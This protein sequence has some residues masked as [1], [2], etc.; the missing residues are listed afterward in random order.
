MKNRDY[1]KLQFRDHS[2]KRLFCGEAERDDRVSLD[3][4]LSLD[5]FDQREL[6]II[7]IRNHLAG[8]DLIVRSTL[9]TQFASP[10]AIFRTQ[11]RSEDATRHRPG[12]VQ[13]TSSCR[14][15]ENG[16]RLIIG[17]G[18]K[19]GRT[20]VTL[21]ENASRRIAREI[22]LKPCDRVAGAPPDA[23]RS[24]RVRDLQFVQA[25]PQPQYV[26]LVNG[27]WANA[28]LRA[29]QTAGKPM[30][31]PLPSICQGC[32]HDLDQLPIAGCKRH[33]MASH[34]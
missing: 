11:R 18:G 28:A 7:G 1:K 10:Q 33:R 3:S 2:L 4:R 29:P 12:F 14:R 23:I 32:I 31:R 26:Q 16:T 9:K 24:L 21:V 25:S 30:S 27:E 8:R 13:V 19:A 34:M 17:E 15:V 5:F 22:T 20:V 6:Q